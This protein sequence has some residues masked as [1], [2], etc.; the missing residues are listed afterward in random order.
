[1]TAQKKGT[2]VPK[3]EKPANNPA[4]PATTLK[5]VEDTKNEESP[6]NE[7]P[8]EVKGKTPESV[9]GIAARRKEGVAKMQKLVD[10]HNH[11]KMKD[12]EVADFMATNDGTKVEMIL[13]NGAGFRV[14]V[15]NTEVIAKTVS[16]I[17]GQ[18]DELLAECEKEIA[19][20][21]L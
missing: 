9:A 20:F 3:S 1:M 16:N 10:R 2:T 18:L 4:A 7:K 8:E 5:K 19:E 21:E 17:R 11:L 6:K 15:S 13:E 14:L 12:E